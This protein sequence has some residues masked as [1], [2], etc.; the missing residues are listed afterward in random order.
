MANVFYSMFLNVLTFFILA[1]FLTFLMFF[2]YF[3]WNVFY[4]YG[5]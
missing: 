2:F 5:P 3:S 1:T 4:I